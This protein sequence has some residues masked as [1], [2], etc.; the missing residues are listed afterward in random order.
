RGV[1]TQLN[2]VFVTRNVEFF[3]N[4]L[5]TQEASGSLDDLELIQEDTHLSENTSSH[6]DEGDQEIDEPQTALL[7]PEVDKW[8]NAMNVEIQSM[9][10]NKV[11]DLF[12]L[13]PKDIRA[14]RILIAIAAFYDYAIRQID[15]KAAFLNGYLFEH[16]YMEQP[17]ASRSYV[18]FLILYADDILIMGN[19]IPMLQDVKS[20]LERCIAM[21]DLEE[22]AYILEIMI[23]RDRLKRS[24]SL[25]QSAYIEKI[26]K[27][28]FME[29]SKRGSAVDW[30]S[31]KQSIFTTSYAEAK[32]IAALDASKEA[33]WV[34]K[35][36]LGLGVVP[37]IKEPIKMIVTIPQTLL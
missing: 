23:Y 10:D 13:P 15:V 26:L 22:A 37:T 18:T 19:N 3:K 2:K 9:K 7:D 20:Y 33:V 28:F 34:R 21:K 24:I 6:H 32:Y 4:S 5:I 27:R 35:V 16:V 14:I 25:C 31:T 29:N 8:L 1:T 36:I 11:W 12:D 30:K 17:E